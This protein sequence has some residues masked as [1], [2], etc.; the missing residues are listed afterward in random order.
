MNI[1]QPEL[2]HD[3]QQRL[4]QMSNEIQSMI[5]AVRELRKSLQETFELF[6]QYDQSN[7]DFESVN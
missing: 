2:N 4:E 1:N 3:D 6:K 7:S 5:V